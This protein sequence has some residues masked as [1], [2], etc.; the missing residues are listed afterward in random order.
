MMGD[1]RGA[2]ELI[3]EE[4]NSDLSDQGESWHRG[5]NLQGE[6]DESSKVV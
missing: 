5:W 6:S 3:G 1:A 2:W 4:S